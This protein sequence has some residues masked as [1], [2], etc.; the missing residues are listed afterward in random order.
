MGNRLMADPVFAAAVDEI[1]AL[2]A[3]Y[4]DFSPAAELAARHADR[5]DYT[6]VAQP[7]LFALQVGLTRVLAQRGVTPV[8][9]MGH[10]VGEVAAV[11]A[12]GALSLPDA[13]KVIYH[14]SRLQGL[15]KARAE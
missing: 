11:W 8:A 6:E 7:T 1:D 9:A 3:E 12:S 5:Y 2:F 4:S 15:T 13:V 10:S 14:R